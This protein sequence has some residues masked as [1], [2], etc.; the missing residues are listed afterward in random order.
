MSNI[1][2]VS[3]DPV[4]RKLVT[5]LGAAEYL[6]VTERWIRRAVEER[7]IP[8]VKLGRLVRFSVEDLDAYVASR[9]V[10]AEADR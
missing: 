5:P 2:C 7:R 6:G 4:A 1:P 3:G 9:R 8:F 10:E